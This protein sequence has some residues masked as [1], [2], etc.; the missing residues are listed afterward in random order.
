MARKELQIFK[1]EDPCQASEI[2]FSAI[3]LTAACGC[4]LPKAMFQKKAM[5]ERLGGWGALEPTCSKMAGQH[6]S[7]F[8][9]KFSN[10]PISRWISGDSIPNGS[11]FEPEISPLSS[12]DFPTVALP[13][14]PGQIAPE[15]CV[16]SGEFFTGIEYWPVRSEFWEE[17]SEKFWNQG[18]LSTRIC[19]CY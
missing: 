17:E 4:N 10:P 6:P 5:L 14:A 18:E 19:H 15:I 12:P 3:C 1:A 11:N 8:S 9:K 13:E 2:W 16:V 7:T